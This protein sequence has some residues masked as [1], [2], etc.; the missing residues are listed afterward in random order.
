M[1]VI[2]FKLCEEDR[3]RLDAVITGLQALAPAVPRSVSI[4]GD[5]ITVEMAHPSTDHPADAPTA[6]LEPPADPEPAA[7]PTPKPISLGEFQKA[8]VTR[9]AESAETKKKV[10][11]LV[12]KY[13]DSVSNIPEDK[14]SEVLAALNE[15]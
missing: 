8:I 5:G 9:C 6:H 3:A 2:E 15:I 12:H 11:A 4:N 14:R 10:Q 1:N 7:A 13:A